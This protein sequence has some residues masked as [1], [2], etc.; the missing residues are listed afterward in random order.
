M[1]PRPALLRRAVVAFPAGLPDAVEAFRRTHDP[2]AAVLPAHVT[3]VFP[4][5]SSLTG[6]QVAAHVAR[7]AAGWP[8]LP[9]TLRGIDAYAGQWVHAR[10]TRGREAIVELH[11]RLYR[12]ALAAFLRREFEYEPHVTLGRATDAAACESMVDAARG[13]FAQPIDVV[14]R[15]LSI[16]A[17][18]A[19]GAAV[20]EREIGLG[21]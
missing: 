16:V 12:G 14:L 13:R 21:G 7:V 6:V 3:L 15:S 10:V 17:L 20:V 9:I 4:F 1:P 19:D 11:A 2:Q 8:A 5:A 18:P